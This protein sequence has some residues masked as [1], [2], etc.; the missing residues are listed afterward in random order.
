MDYFFINDFL[1]PSLPK[2]IQ[3]ILETS[4]IARA[5]EWF[6]QH[7]KDLLPEME[8]KV[9][10]GMAVF[11]MVHNDSIHFEKTLD[12][13]L[14]INHPFYLLG[15]DQDR[16]RITLLDAS[17]AVA[18][19][20]DPVS[21]EQYFTKLVDRGAKPTKMTMDYLN[22]MGRYSQLIHI[23][24]ASEKAKNFPLNGV[25][26]AVVLRE[27]LKNPWKNYHSP[28]TLCQWLWDH[29]E[30]LHEE[31]SEDDYV[32]LLDVLKKE[33]LNLH[34]LPN[35]KHI[36]FEKIFDLDQQIMIKPGPKDLITH[37][38]GGLRIASHEKACWNLARALLRQGVCLP[39]E[40]PDVVE[41][42]KHD[43]ERTQLLSLADQLHLQAQVHSSTRTRMGGR[44]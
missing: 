21:A 27:L 36:S 1:L 11:C 38:L 26:N 23:M 30:F 12:E 15:L 24:N 8:Q 28:E 32:D 25:E 6:E 39:N 3:Q 22:T 7:H 14:D 43:Q 37:T 20:S 9:L 18:T 17:S 44:L 19:W 40:L 4:S 33:G 42:D 16:K 35:R 5:Q 10:L 34:Q 2:D 41:Q 31:M 13:G 29:A